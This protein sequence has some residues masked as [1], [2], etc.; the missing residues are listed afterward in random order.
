M[1]ERIGDGGEFDD[2][3]TLTENGGADAVGH[4]GD[5]TD[6][7]AGVVVLTTLD[8]GWGGEGADAGGG[9]EGFEGL[10]SE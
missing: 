7:V 6:T 8:G 3:D 10:H 4:S 2:V 1:S 5:G 9:E